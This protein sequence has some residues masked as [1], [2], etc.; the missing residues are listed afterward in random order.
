MGY[1]PEGLEITDVYTQIIPSFRTLMGKD[2]VISKN[3]LEKIL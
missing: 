2:F 3:I 1:I